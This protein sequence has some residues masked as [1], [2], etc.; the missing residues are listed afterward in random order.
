MTI[1]ADTPVVD[2]A[3]ETIVVNAAAIPIADLVAIESRSHS[4]A[5]AE[6]QDALIEVAVDSVRAIDLAQARTVPQTSN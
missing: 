2:L 1:E 3:G 6:I 4:L 5:V